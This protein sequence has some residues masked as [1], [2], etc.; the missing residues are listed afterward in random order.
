MGR[1]LSNEERFALATK[2][3][4]I[5]LGTMFVREYSLKFTRLV[6]L[7]PRIM[8]ACAA[9]AMSL[10]GTLFP[11]LGSWN[12]KRIRRV[13][14]NYKGKK[15]GQGNN[16][17]SRFS[18]CNTQ[19]SSGWKDHICHY[20]CTRVHINRDCMKWFHEMANSSGQRNNSSA[21]VAAKNPPPGNP[22]KTPNARGNGTGSNLSY[23]SPYFS[24]DFGVEPELLLES[25]YVDTL[26]GVPVIA[27]T[28]YRNCAVVIKNRQTIA[29]LFKLE[30]VDFDVIIGMDW[31]SESYENVD[32]RHKFVRFKFHNELLIVWK[33][34]IAKP[35]GMFISYLK[36]HKMISKGCIYHLVVINDTQ[37]VVPEFEFVPIVNEFPGVFPEDLPG[38]PPDRVI[39]F[40]IDI[41]FDTQ[42]ISVPPYRMAPAELR[43][44][45]DQ[46]KDLLDKGF[47][48]LSTSP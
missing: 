15:Q 4:K 47:I 32:C 14:R 26:A 44:L 11:W 19:H 2:F 48:R 29:D 40:G 13:R 42:S 16:N 9:A 41:I 10:T 5:E 1:Y 12:N 30:M 27:S 36:A 43:E 37:P 46:L 33:G 3:K 20:C 21:P 35:R 18:Q 24:L 45:N 7:I 8:S 28:V 34:E 25:F 17:Q 22:N 38:I 39:D 6:R 31:L 23:V